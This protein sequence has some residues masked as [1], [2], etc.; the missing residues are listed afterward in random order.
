MPAAIT[1]VRLGAG[2]G[3]SGHAA[4]VAQCRA[5]YAFCP[6]RVVGKPPTTST[7]SWVSYPR[8]SGKPMICFSATVCDKS[9]AHYEAT[10]EAKQW[11]STSPTSA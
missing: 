9:L 8:P 6:Y 10:G 11:K 4:G 7:V 5:E 2:T 1:P 3:K